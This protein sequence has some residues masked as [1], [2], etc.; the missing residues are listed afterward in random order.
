MAPYHETPALQCGLHPLLI[1]TACTSGSDGR[2]APRP[3][4][5]GESSACP[6]MLCAAI[7][8][9][10]IIAIARSD[11]A[12]IYELPLHLGWAF[13][14]H[15]KDSTV[16]PAAGSHSRTQT[17]TRRKLFLTS[18]SPPRALFPPWPTLLC[19]RSFSST[20]SCVDAFA[21]TP[22]AR[23]HTPRL[24]LVFNQESKFIPGL[25]APGG[26]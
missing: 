12:A 9:A 19:T 14:W 18:G 13:H 21:C 8:Q 25:C 11:T 10:M 5:C 1:P 3:S 17:F 2:V 24:Q 6:R 26:L 7:V 22:S 23:V 4:R 16:S 20:R 15:R